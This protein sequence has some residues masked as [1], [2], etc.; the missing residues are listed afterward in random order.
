MQH[1]AALLSIR[2]IHADRIFAGTKTV[3]LR[4]TRPGFVAGQL[5]LV[6]ASAPRMQIIGTF[7]VADIAAGDPQAM[8][9]KVRST[10]EI[11]QPHFISYFDGAR[12][13]YAIRISKA[14]LLVNPI[15]LAEIRLGLPGFHPPQVYRYLTHD[16]VERLVHRNAVKAA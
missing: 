15:S 1:C 5:I 10:A 16:Q 6:Y 13:A 14:Q 12:T 8:W 11:T 3:E 9:S 4:R 2:P 7:R